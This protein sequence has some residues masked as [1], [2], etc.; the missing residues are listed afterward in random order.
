M[1]RRWSHRP[2]R[3]RFVLLVVAA[4]AVAG[5]A[6]LAVARAA[7][8]S[9]S[10][11]GHVDRV[12]QASTGIAVAGW[13]IDPDT[14]ASIHVDVYVDGRGTRL[15]ANHTR[16][17]IGTK[18]PAYGSAHGFSATIAAGQ[19]SHSVCI[20]AINVGSGSNTTLLCTTITLN[21]NP[22]GALDWVRQTT[23][24]FAVAGWAIDP[25]TTSPIYVDVYF[26]G[27][28]TRL[29]ANTIRSDIGTKYPAFGSAHGYLASFDATQGSH[30]VCAYGINVGLGTGS[31]KLGCR[32]ILVNFNPIGR[33]ETV[34]QTSTGI[35]LTGWAIDPNTTSPINVDI[36]TDGNPRVRL[37]ANLTRTDIG[38]AHPG[39][40]DDHG[41]AANVT[42]AEGSHNVCAYGI[43][44]GLGTGNPLLNCLA[45]TI[46]Y[47][48]KTSLDTATQQTPGVH[49]TGWSV[50]PDTTSPVNVVVT[51]NGATLGTLV[52]N[53]AGSTHPGHAF[54]GT[55]ALD[56]GTYTICASGVNLLQ[57]SGTPAPSCRTVTLNFNPYG[58][59]DS[60]TRDSTGHAAK[61][62]GWAIDPDVPTTPLVIVVRIDGVLMPSATANATRTDIATLYP[63]T[64]TSH[65]L[66]ATYAVNDNEHTICL[67]AIN[68]GH[69][70]SKSL[71]CRI[72]NAL[73]PV[74][75]S[76]PRY[77]T[78]VGG[79]GSVAVSWSPPLSDGGAPWSSY[80][81]TSSPGG[82][83]KTVSATTLSTTISGLASNTSYRFYV[84][85]T[86]VA[87]KSPAGVSPLVTTQASPPPQ[88]TP[89]PISTSR[90]IRNITGGT[91]TDL[92]KLKA[93][94]AADAYA[95]PS[96]HAYLILLDIGGQDQADGGVVLS[97]TTR[98]ISYGDLVKNLNAYVDGY[99]SKQKPS[100]PVTIAIGTNNDMD[101]SSTSGAAW[102]RSVVNPVVSYASKYLGMRIAGAND[103]EPGFRGTYSQTYSWLTG[104]LGA[105]SARF[106]FNGSA[107]G[108]AWTIINGGCNN[109]WTMAGLYNLSA[110]ASSTRMSGLPQI[111]N[112]TMAAQWK[113][114]S[115][116]GV[117]QSRPRVNFGGP[118]TEWTACSQA[119]TC[120]SMT[121]STA[122]TAL[123]NQLQSST[124][125][126]VGSLPYSTDLRIDR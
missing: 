126:K 112:N 89:A 115:L 15:T 119:G 47:K 38:A 44:V 110:G 35:S 5:S 12:A 27:H 55:F 123:W 29:T 51:A 95:N 104:Y 74:V 109:G 69:G 117:A 20:Y 98:F 19:G 40:G 97:A 21:F 106:V 30:T 64:G 18:Y 10:P 49:V 57:G 102:A 59:F 93:E 75:P 7:T 118:L 88:T 87:G 16:S 100:A 41:F 67:V 24:G 84:V 8:T 63:G 122:W 85:A 34:R 42:L 108:C 120:Y 111:Y 6:F 11:F 105:T 77:V 9:H 1:I 66:A 92:S 116:T 82:I 94:G 91:S 32:T 81:V 33:L 48:P 39:Y 99:A 79:Y 124:A 22:F 71:G 72:L 61:L 56:N 4:L 36:Y 58:R 60:V 113:Y 43:N 125:L 2:R 73:H 50:D 80:T 96:G 70:V 76:A 13:A 114:I 23:N 37:T 53:G 14:T 103:I 90:Y 86:N 17:D 78:G 45:I 28:G 26:D 62:L 25:N 31:T 3:H 52:A 65:G 68:Q 101:V 107:D 54:A 121:G 83:T 46:D